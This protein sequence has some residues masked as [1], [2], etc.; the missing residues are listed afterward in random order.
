ML[1]RFSSVQLCATLWTVACQAALSMGFSKA[2]IL[3]W[4]A[5]TS[6]R[7]SSW[8]RDPTCGVPYVFCIT[9]RFFITEPPKKP[10][11]LTNYGQLKYTSEKKIGYSQM[12]SCCPYI[13][14][15][16]QLTCTTPERRIFMTGGQ[17]GASEIGLNFYWH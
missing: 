13:P 14:N 6:S 10:K 3:E 16:I 15:L 9:G 4:V 7:G 2:R 11:L 8:P 5:M 12:H 17:P 1:S